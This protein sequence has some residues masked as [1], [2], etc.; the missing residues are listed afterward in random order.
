[1]PQTNTKAEFEQLSTNV[2]TWFIPE[3]IPENPENWQQ[4]KTEDALLYGAI[5]YPQEIDKETEEI[6]EKGFTEDLEI[7]APGNCR[8][9]ECTDNSITLEFDGVSQPEIGALDRYTMIISGGIKVSNSDVITVLNEDETAE[10]EMTIQEAIEGKNIVK[11][12]TK[13]AYTG[14]EKI[15]VILKNFRR[16]YT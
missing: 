14:T 2:L 4:N 16:I 3:Y 7:V 6:T 9:I 10:V 12:G 8:I 11:M 1:M 15:Q 5:I 13:I